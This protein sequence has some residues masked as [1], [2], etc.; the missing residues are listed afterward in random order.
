V[1]PRIG[2]RAPTPPVPASSARAIARYLVG[3]RPVLGDACAIRNEW[4]RGLGLLIQE[5]HSGD[6]L[7]ITRGSG[8]LGREFG[9]QFRHTRSRIDLLSPPPECDVCHAAVRAWAQCLLSSCEAL[10]EVGRSGQL[11]GLR[12]AQARLA[13]GRTQAHRFNDEY[14]RL[15]HELRRRVQTARRRHDRLPAGRQASPS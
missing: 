15:S 4:V 13:D 12:D 1:R 8:G 7:R 3:L 9:Q 10:A 14:A 6:A 11:H 2:S 5:A